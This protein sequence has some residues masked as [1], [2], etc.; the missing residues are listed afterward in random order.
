MRTES[1]WPGIVIISTSAVVVDLPS[2]VG[3]PWSVVLALWFLLICPGASV[4]RVFGLRDLTA[5]LAV[6]VP[7]SLSLVTLTSAV[8]FY[9]H[10]W[11]LDREF[12]LLLLTCLVGLLWSQLASRTD[13]EGE[14]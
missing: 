14:S 8:L 13:I 3:F 12:G 6:I 9:G 10:L 7:L 2:G 4:V 11:S 1:L 5:E